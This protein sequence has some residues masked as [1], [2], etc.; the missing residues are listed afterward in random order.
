MTRKYKLTG[1][2]R[3]V[4]FLVMISP[5]CYVGAMQYQNNPDVRSFIDNLRSEANLKFEDISTEAEHIEQV[6]ELDTEDIKEEINDLKDRIKEL[7]EVLEHQTIKSDQ[8]E[9]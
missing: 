9:V 1:F 7:E 5:F 4:I 3:F 8:I 2:A 6:K